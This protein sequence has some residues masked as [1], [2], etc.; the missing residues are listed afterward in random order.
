MWPI[1]AV[2]G[3]LCRDRIETIVVAVLS[4]DKTAPTPTHQI[5]ETVC[6]LAGISSTITRA[7]VRMI[8]RSL[9]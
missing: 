5:F 7:I 3:G 9:A 1:D 2:G 4:R 8:S 6:H